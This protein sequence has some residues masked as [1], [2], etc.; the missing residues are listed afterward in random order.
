MDSNW[1]QAKNNLSKLS[2]IMY[3]IPSDL[4]E[5]VYYYYLAAFYKIQKYPKNK[6]KICPPLWFFLLSKSL[7]IRKCSPEVT[8][9][10]L[11]EISHIYPP[12]EESELF[13]LFF[14]GAAEALNR[15]KDAD[16]V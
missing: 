6:Q 15:L 12:A 14:P 16:S 11:P 2:E 9:E 7:A 5:H 3:F 1:T 10:D 4:T 13:R 8:A